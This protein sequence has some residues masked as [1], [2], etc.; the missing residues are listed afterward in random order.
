LAKL[1]KEKKN[2]EK[3]EKQL[4]KELVDYIGKEFD[5]RAEYFTF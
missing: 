4:S 5:D 1:E 2:Q 3:K